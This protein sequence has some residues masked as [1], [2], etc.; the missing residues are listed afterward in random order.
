[1]IIKKCNKCGAVVKV[2][3]D[4]T[5]EDCG[6]MCCGEKMTEQ[7]PNSVDVSFEKH[8]PTYEVDGD[9]INIHIDH[10]M[11]DDHYI[12]WVSIVDGN[13]EVTFYMKPGDSTDIRHEYIPG[14]KIYAYCNKHGLWEKE[15]E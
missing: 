15:V 3:N 7:K 11:D 6:I 4:C 12:E 1:M 9:I 14:S 5:C 10:V 2:L 13:N 8:V